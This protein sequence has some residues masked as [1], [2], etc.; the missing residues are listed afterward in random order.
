MRRGLLGLC[1][2][3]IVLSAAA[4]RAEMRITEWMYKG[5]NGEFIEFTNVGS[6]PVDMADWHYSDSDRGSHDLN[7]SAFGVVAPG[8]S[9]ILTDASEAAFRTAWGLSSS[10]KIIG[11]NTNSNLDRND[12]IN[13]YD[14]AEVLVDRLTYGD[15]AFSGSVRANG[16]S[17][18][19][20]SAGV[21]GANNVYGWV[22]SVAGDAFGSH[23]AA[24]DIGNP[25]HYAVPEPTS[26][27]LALI[28]LAGVFATRRRWF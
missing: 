16:V 26:V 14:A 6:A 2:L 25:G 23:A 20:G 7:I 8:E 4:A 11:S 21:L 10:V 3:A 15:E 27:V 17:G 24:G 13:L 22:K 28:G 9:V 12:E 1:F 5:A 18:N 19:P